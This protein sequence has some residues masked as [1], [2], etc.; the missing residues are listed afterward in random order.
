[1]KN[2]TIQVSFTMPEDL[3]S[4]FIGELAAFTE[5]YSNK[6]HQQIWSIVKNEYEKATAL[7]HST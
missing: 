3:K 2:K 1:M 7:H 6:K 5:E 4:D